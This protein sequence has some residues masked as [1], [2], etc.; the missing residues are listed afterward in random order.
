MVNKRVYTLSLP[1]IFPYRDMTLGIYGGYQDL[2]KKLK[3]LR[4]SKLPRALRYDYSWLKYRADW[5]TISVGSLLAGAVVLRTLLA[6]ASTR[7]LVNKIL[8]KTLC[9]LFSG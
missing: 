1:Y 4:E 7:S 9:C 8:R 6:S 3:T 5:L 2:I